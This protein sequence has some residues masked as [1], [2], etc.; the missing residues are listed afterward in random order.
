MIKTANTFVVLLSAL[1]LT[2]AGQIVSG[3]QASAQ[4]AAQMSLQVSDAGAQAANADSATSAEPSVAS[5]TR[6]AA[7]KKTPAAR[8][9][10][11][12]RPK[13]ARR[14]QTTR[15]RRTVRRHQTTRR[16]R[17][18][19]RQRT[20]RRAPSVGRYRTSRR[21]NP[22]IPRRGYEGFAGIGLGSYCSYRREPWRKCTINRY[23]EE[24]CRTVGWRRI[25]HCY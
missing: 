19:R 4:V 16:P 6:R 3:S 1:S 25:Q 9:K 8:K 11:T 7:P 10:T 24:Q 13:S 21:S 5:E 17:S 12:R 15:R 20:T 14:K 23:G 22:G 18:V 2:A